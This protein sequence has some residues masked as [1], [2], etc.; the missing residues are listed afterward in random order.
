MYVCILHTC[1]TKMPHDRLCLIALVS[2]Q[3]SCLF[4][5]KTTYQHTHMYI[6]YYILMQ[7]H[8]YVHSHTARFPAELLLFQ[9]AFQCLFIL[10]HFC[11]CN[12]NVHMHSCNFCCAV[13]SLSLLKTGFF[14]LLIV[15]VVFFCVSH[16]FIFVLLHL[17][18]GKFFKVKVKRIV[19]MYT[20]W[21]LLHLLI[22]WN[23]LCTQSLW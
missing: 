20:L 21:Y 16:L 7:L 8:T 5:H 1:P 3:R 4:I 17:F 10:S 9:A 15:S 14:A 11:F 12:F 18:Y 2:W 13:I 6:L 22:L 19:V 23:L